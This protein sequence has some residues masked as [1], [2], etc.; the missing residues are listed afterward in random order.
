M[1]SLERQLDIAVQQYNAVVKQNK[2]LQKELNA[3]KEELS[4]IQHNCTREGCK[5][6]EDDTYKVFYKCKARRTLE[7][8]RDYCVKFQ[9]D[10]GQPDA[11]CIEI[12]NRIA[13]SM[14]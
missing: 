14:R 8:L 6:F 7:D 13:D 12:V 11:L 10:L 3:V 4:N 5:Y 9:N 1:S 2:D